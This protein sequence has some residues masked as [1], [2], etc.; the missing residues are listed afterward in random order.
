MLENI[1]NATD[2]AFSDKVADMQAE[3]TSALMAKAGESLEQKRIEVAQ[4]LITQESTEEYYEEVEELD[5]KLSVTDGIKAWIDDFIKSDDPRFEGKSKEERRQMAIGAFYSAKKGTNEE[6]E[7][8][9]VS[10]PTLRKYVGKNVASTMNQ[11]FDEIPRKRIKG[12]KRASD[13]LHQKQ[14]PK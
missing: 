4:S 5:E 9:E 1:K 10:E 13:K 2:Y 12:L 7:L 14:F 11:N 3:I 8:D 6:V